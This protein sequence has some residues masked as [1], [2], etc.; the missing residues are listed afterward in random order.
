ME[1]HQDKV[2]TEPKETRSS[3]L[4]CA[5]C[6]VDIDKLLAEMEDDEPSA[7]KSSQLVFDI[8]NL[9]AGTLNSA[10]EEAIRDTEQ[11]QD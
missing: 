5:D 9:G 10:S 7:K 8:S 11:G 4:T 1:A 6:A 2:N 3:R